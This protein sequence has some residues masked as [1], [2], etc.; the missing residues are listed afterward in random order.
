MDVAAAQAAAHVAPIARATAAPGVPRNLVAAANT[1]LQREV[2]GFVNASN[3]GSASVGYQSWNLSLL[4]T[5]AFFGLPVQPGD[6]SI[7]TSSTGWQ[8][9]YSQTMTNFVNAAH[10]KGVRVIIAFN[11]RGNI[12]GQLS[13]ASAQNT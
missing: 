12:C 10:A 7:D 11:A 8:V 13:A 9:A 2:F 1:P 6:G 5:V 3:L 4:T